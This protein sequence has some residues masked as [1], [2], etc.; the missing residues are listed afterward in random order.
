VRSPVRAVVAVIVGVAAVF[1][2]GAVLAGH[3]ALYL[4]F[5]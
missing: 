3:A 2:L 4:D 1:W 5:G